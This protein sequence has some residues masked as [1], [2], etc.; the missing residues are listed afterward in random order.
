MARETEKRDQFVVSRA[1]VSR[2]PQHE[3]LCPHAPVPWRLG[4]ELHEFLSVRLF[5]AH[6]FESVL[7]ELTPEGEEEGGRDRS[8]D[9]LEEA[10]REPRLLGRGLPDRLDQPERHVDHPSRGRGRREA[11]ADAGMNPAELGAA[12]TRHPCHRIA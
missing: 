2:L 6:W 11:L 3:N 12:L 8:R 9:S 5:S 7:P 4:Q 10:E 1:E